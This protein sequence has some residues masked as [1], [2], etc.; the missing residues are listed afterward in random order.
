[1]HWRQW[2]QECRNPL[3]CVRS[4]PKPSRGEA[5]LFWLLPVQSALPKPLSMKHPEMFCNSAL[6]V[7]TFTILF[8]QSYNLWY[9][10]LNFSYVLV[11][12]LTK[13]CLKFFSFLNTSFQ[14]CIYPHCYA[15]VYSD[16]IFSLS[17]F[18]MVVK[19]FLFFPVV[20]WVKRGP[21]FF[22]KWSNLWFS[23]AGSGYVI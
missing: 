11:S 12:F 4:Q 10:D 9:F 1:M 17:E 5:L 14:K 15:E 8:C 2:F 16:C 21:Q 7:I 20:W 3:C 23:T 13:K 6:W 19:Y 18:V 22:Q